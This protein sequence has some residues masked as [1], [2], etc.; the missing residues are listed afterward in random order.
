MT[1][2][3]VG[4]V[5][6]FEPGRVTAVADGAVVIVRR[7]AEVTAFRN[8]CGHQDSPIDGG[9]LRDGRLICPQHFWAFDPATGADCRGGT[10]LEPVAVAVVDGEV[11]V[12]VPAAETPVSIREQLLAH[13]R[14]WTR[15]VSHD[16]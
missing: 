16:T 11:V 1:P 13:A 14:T 3:R 5:D 8:R 9:W 7:G 4:P 6:R 15:E 2:T 12:D 10:P